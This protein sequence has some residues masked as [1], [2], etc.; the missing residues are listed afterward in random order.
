LYWADQVL[1]AGSSGRFAVGAM[2]V[3][4]VISGAYALVGS[5]VFRR[6]VATSRER[7]DLD[8]A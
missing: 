8:L 2:V 4:V 1:R 7:G 6:V 5:W 3:L